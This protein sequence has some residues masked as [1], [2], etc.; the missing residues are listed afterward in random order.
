MSGSKPPTIKL[1]VQQY[2][3]GDQIQSFLGAVERADLM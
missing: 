2:T 1:I 3:N